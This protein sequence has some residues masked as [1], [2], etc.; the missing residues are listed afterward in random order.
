MDSR[1]HGSVR[2]GFGKG[3]VKVHASLFLRRT[4]PM[5]L[6]RFAVVDELGQGPL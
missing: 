4:A 3:G 5:S 2:A 1:A 6:G